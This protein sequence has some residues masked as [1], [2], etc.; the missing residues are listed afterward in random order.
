MNV[1]NDWKR[2]LGQ[3][4]DSLADGWRDL[5]ERAAGAMT[6]FSPSKDGNV[7]ATVEDGIPSSWGLLASDV[8]DNDESVVVRPEAPGMNKRDFSIEV[9]DGVLVVEGEKRFERE[10]GTGQYRVMEC[11]YGRFRRAVGLP[12]PVR[13]DQARATYRDGVLRVELPKAEAARARRI[14]VQT[15]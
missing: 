6:R 10:R 3:V 2:S 8:F 1:V 4:W 12:V 5:R 11:A 14:A 9:R 7:P 13:E 15:N